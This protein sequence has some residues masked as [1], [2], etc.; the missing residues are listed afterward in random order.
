MLLWNKID[1]TFMKFE[2][3]ITL[4]KFKFFKFVQEVGKEK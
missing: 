1:F 3:Q 4:Y 2:F